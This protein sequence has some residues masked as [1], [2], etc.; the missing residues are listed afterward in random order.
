M[1]TKPKPT[2][3]SEESE[4][5]A[6]VTHEL[7][8]LQKQ[9]WCLLSLG[10]AL[11]VM[12]TIAIGAAPF[13]SAVTVVF[14][15]VLLLIGGISQV[16]SSFWAG[17]WS[18][19]MVQLLIGILYSVLGLLI[20]DSPVES[21]VALTLMIAAVF[22]ISGIFRIVA[23][24]TQ[25]FHDWGWVMLNGVI[26]LLLGILIYRGWPVSG[27]WLIGLFV[28]IEMVLNGWFWV[29]LGI[30]LRRFGKASAG[31]PEG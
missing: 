1:V 2:S 17:K 16:I 13:I 5:A 3:V 20:I 19:M 21:A 11:V 29:M 24:M 28:G 23:A 31:S 25:K 22:I 8:H 10:I 14:F 6:C 18:G 4:V 7:A 9:W 27:L 12:G 30:G 15:G 26:T